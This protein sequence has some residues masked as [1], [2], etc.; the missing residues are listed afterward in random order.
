MQSALYIAYHR[1]VAIIYI[2]PKAIVAA[3]VN[4]ETVL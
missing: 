1:Y 3:H 2:Q 4:D